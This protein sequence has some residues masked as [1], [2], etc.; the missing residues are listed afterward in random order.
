MGKFRDKYNEMKAKVDNWIDTTIKPVLDNGVAAVAGAW[1][2][3]FD[4]TPEGVVPLPIVRPEYIDRAGRTIKVPLPTDGSY[5]EVIVAG[6]KIK[7][8]KATDK[9]EV[10]LLTVKR[11][12]SYF[13]LTPN[14][15]YNNPPPISVLATVNMQGQT[16]CDHK[17]IIFEP[18]FT[19]CDGCVGPVADNKCIPQIEL[20]EW[21]RYDTKNMING[22]FGL[23]TGQSYMYCLRGQGI[24]WCDDSGQR[25]PILSYKEKMREA[26][27]KFWSGEITLA[28]LKGELSEIAKSI[29]PVNLSTGNFTYDKE[30]IN[31]NGRYPLSFK[32]FY[33]AIND[34]SGSLGYDWNHNYEIYISKSEKKVIVHLDDG[35]EDIY[36]LGED[37]N[38]Y[39]NWPGG[40]TLIE[41]DIGYLYTTK[42][43]KKYYFDVE[44]RNTR[45][46]D[47]NGN[48]ISLYYKEINE[49]IDVSN[50]INTDNK[51][52]DAVIT[53]FLVIK[54]E[55]DTGLTLTF[56]Y[57]SEKQLEKVTDH[58]GR[59]VSYT[60]EDNHLKTVTNILGDITTYDYTENGKLKSVENAH[61]IKPVENEF[62]HLDRTVKQHFPDGGE[63]SFEYIDDEN[64][65]ILT[66]Q[67]G[68]TLRYIHDGRKRHIE[69]VFNNEYGNYESTERS[70][71]DDQNNK[72]RAY[73][74]N[75]KWRNYR[76]DNHGNKI[77]DI[78]FL[79]NQ[80]T[81]TYNDL[82]RLTGVRLP[83][84]AVYSYDYDSNGNLIKAINP[85]GY[86]QTIDYSD[87]IKN[88][89]GLPVM[90]TMPDGSQSKI[91]YDE[92]GNIAKIIDANL[93]ETYFKYDN[94]NRVIRTINPNRN[95]LAFAY[96]EKGDITEIIN[97]EG[98]LKT[99]EYNKLGKV[100]KVTDFDGSVTSYTYNAMGKPETITN[101][102]GD[103]TS[104]TYDLMWNIESVTDP[105]GNKQCFFYNHHNRLVKVTDPGGNETRYEHDYAGN[106]TAVISP[107]GE[108]TE[109][110][111]DELSRR[112]KV[113]AADEAVTK[114]AYDNV[115]NLIKL[116]DP[117]GGEHCFDYDP[118]G[119][120]IKTAD[121]LNNT[122]T[123]TYTP[124]GKIETITDAIGLVT[125]YTYYPGGKIRSVTRPEKTSEEYTYDGNGNIITVKD[126]LNN[127]TAIAYD[128][129]DRVKTITNPLGH[130]KHFSY[131]ALGNIISITDE[132][133]NTT[134]YTYSPTGKVIK[135]IDALGHSTD[136]SYDKADRLTGME[137]YRLYD[138][139]YAT[140]K[141]H[142]LT[143]R[144]LIDNNLI[145][146]SQPAPPRNLNEIQVTKWDYDK[147]GKVTKVANPLG[148]YSTYKYDAAGRLT[149]KTDEDSLETLYQYDI[150]GNLA[151]ILYAD[152]KTVELSYNPLRK[153]SEMKDWLGI[154]TIET[155]A[156]GR[157]TKVT[158]PEDRII[159]YEYDALSRRN[160]ITYPDGN[161][162]AYHYNKAGHLDEV[163]SSSGTVNYRYDISGR[164]SERTM[165]D[166]IITKYT[167]DPL[168]RLESLTHKKN[169]AILDRFTYTYDPTG[170]ITKIEKERKDAPID[171]GTFSYTY[172]PLNRLTKAVNHHTTKS[173]QYDALGNRILSSKITEESYLNHKIIDTEYTYNQRN[174]L[175]RTHE[176]GEEPKDYT[177]DLRGN[178]NQILTNGIITNEYTF[179]ATNRMTKAISYDGNNQSTAE[180]T[181][182]GLLKR[183]KRLETL[184]TNKLN[185]TLADIRQNSVP[186][187]TTEINYIL[188]LTKPY[189]DLLATETI[190]K[191]ITSPQRFVWSEELLLSEFHDTSL[192]DE[193]NSF[194]YLTDHLGSPIRLI[195]NEQEQTL[196][197]DEFGAPLI[198]PKTSNNSNIIQKLPNPFGFTGYQ[199]SLS[200]GDSLYFV[201]NRF[202]NAPTG[203]FVSQ[204][205]INDDYNVYRHCRSNPL[206]YV[207]LNGLEPTPY[208]AALMAQHIYT[209]TGKDVEKAYNVKNY[210]GYLD[211]WVLIE[212]ITG[213][214]D[215]KMGVYMKRDSEINTIEYALVNKGTTSWWDNGPG[216]DLINNI[217]QPFGKSNDMKESID[218]AIKFVNKNPG[219]EITMIGHSKGGA[220]AAANAVTTNMNAIIFN[221]AS[222]NLNAYDLDASNYTGNM[223]AF[224]VRDEILNNIFGAISIPIDEV[225]YL[226]AQYKTPWFIIGPVR[227]L[228]NIY[229]SVQNHSMNAVI[230]ALIEKE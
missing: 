177:Y 165:P 51:N 202:Y 50:S 56:T 173:Y 38:Y 41:S 108:R 102:S 137:Q 168:G 75:G 214:D 33:N 136:Y 4:Y 39:P 216:N 54:A 113:I 156:I 172:D 154:T 2:S 81:F 20:K 122:T 175:I 146:H 85:L 185:I 91:S 47:L 79:A 15:T 28:E 201:Q 78:D 1:D 77:A 10:A 87:S 139:T 8:D 65:V 119:Q 179:D 52:T 105:L 194:N 209:A 191:N 36:G 27:K 14:Q 130:Q 228:L 217:Q 163:I 32:R 193:N 144:S 19:N 58:T 59:E 44:G 93:N 207:D 178:L 151:K 213:T 182:N 49:N 174:Q 31:L 124:L 221:P 189:N 103:T 198:I 135:V 43:Q 138:E 226:D 117:L 98:N 82:N 53:P 22:N 60:Y 94:L 90:V 208:E 64:T 192:K 72:I 227:N 199:A 6:A 89:K 169:S 197:Y 164:L 101:P 74:R 212:I 48:G 99:Y 159:S 42:D 57:N 129:M 167:T 107:M 171:S 96:N 100:T 71:Y 121:P 45:Q 84:G 92:K 158:D 215:L 170:N 176:C 63:M 109:I 7:C 188:D 30:D 132:N 148:S 123:Y 34:Q 229:N 211:E 35:R 187:P 97:A 88:L 150:V 86:E 61:G 149:L 16:Q 46:E 183:V 5:E 11:D 114:Y 66:E 69:T 110:E 196:A 73:D 190:N 145:E 218:E 111:Y 155:D 204:D 205:F 180:Y 181:Y 166:N 83:N 206:R 157:T 225:V 70:E 120:L 210:S 37:N 219:V 55:E 3:F 142:H 13:S 224:I 17:N 76:Y 80:T 230:N 143:E 203:Q 200:G 134:S 115:S 24:L 160:A 161:K 162:V 12:E 9:E 118:A 153:L 21:Q 222:V 18:V 62:D 195:G 26:Y 131:D 125:T 140:I 152:G 128:F 141:E 29:D 126:T 127:S 68:N 186:D 147:N 116:T 133:G 184:P 95:E 106:L 223:T 40:C 104:I 112:K 23:L 67:N 220:E 25:R